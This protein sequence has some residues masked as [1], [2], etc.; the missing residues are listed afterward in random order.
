MGYITDGRTK[1]SAQDSA[2]D[3]RNFLDGADPA[4]PLVYIRQ[5]PRHYCPGNSTD[6]DAALPLL[7]RGWVYQERLLSPRILHLGAIDLMW[8]CNKAIHCHCDNVHRTMSARIP[9]SANKPPKQ[10]H[11][12]RL[13]A[14]KDKEDACLRWMRIV[15][16]YSALDLTFESDRI[17]AI[18]G[19]AKQFRRCLTNTRYVAGLWEECL[20]DGML[21]ALVYD[22]DK[23]KPRPSSPLGLSWSWAS[24]PGP[25]KYELVTFLQD[26]LNRPTVEKVVYDCDNED[27]FMVLKNGSVTLHGYLVA[28]KL[29]M[30]KTT[31]QTLFEFIRPGVQDCYKHTILDY[32]VDDIEISSDWNSVCPKWAKTLLTDP[33]NEHAS[34]LFH[35]LLE[36]EDMIDEKSLSLDQD[37]TLVSVW[38]YARDVH[39]AVMGRTEDR[40]GDIEEVFLLLE[41]VDRAQNVHKRIGKSFCQIAKKKSDFENKYIAA[42]AIW[43]LGLGYRQSFTIV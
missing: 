41:C 31:K 28:V 4:G 5:V 33:E 1:M 8:E 14:E 38:Q 36:G 3:I 43:V 39:Y 18:A 21:W 22:A 25:T 35:P 19:V 23:P 10:L 17:P 13:L 20:I 29:R 30:I 32:D 27:E 7:R 24:V 16:E 34:L 2:E 9:T 12:D 26:A 6:N 11:A 37:E 15:Q 42:D 40:N